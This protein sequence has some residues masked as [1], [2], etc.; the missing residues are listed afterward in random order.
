MEIAGA[1]L[2]SG[3]RAV[4]TI[5]DQVVAGVRMP[6]EDP[7]VVET[8]VADD[9]DVVGHLVHL[10]DRLSAEVVRAAREIV[11]EAQRRGRVVP[12]DPGRLPSR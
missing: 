6:A 4:V 9:L 3:K 8:L 10:P 1:E 7:D 11:N 12:H 5:E 2:C